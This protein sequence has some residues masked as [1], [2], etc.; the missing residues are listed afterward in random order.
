MV[1]RAVEGLSPQQRAVF[2]LRFREEM[3]PAAIAEQLDLPARQVRSQL[4]RAVQRIREA[5]A[6]EMHE[7]G[8][9]RTEY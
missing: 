9:R 5:V 6:A 1:G 2:L 8:K 4:H 3:L 7:P